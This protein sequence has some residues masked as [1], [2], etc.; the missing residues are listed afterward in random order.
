MNK[1]KIVNNPKALETDET[2][3]IG[4][5][6]LLWCSSFLGICGLHRFYSG[7]YFTGTIW[8]A[9]LGLLGMGQFLDLFFIPGMVEQKNLK[10]LKKRFY[11]G[12]VTFNYLPQEQIERVIE[13]D[14]PKSDTQIILELAKK[15][16]EGIS[17]G[18][19]IIATNKTVPEMKELLKSLYKDGLIEM[20]NHPETGAVIYKFL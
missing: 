1:S 17:I 20:E 14:P 7:K 4:M 10:I 13:K 11:S 12:D 3:N 19:C 8:L 2:R 18:D 9:T 15:H 16:P 6:Y 5:A